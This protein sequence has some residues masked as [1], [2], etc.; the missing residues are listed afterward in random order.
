MMLEEVI[1][2]LLVWTLTALVGWAVGRI[3]STAKADKEEREALYAGVRALLRSELMRTHHQAI[4]DGFITTTDREVMQRTYDAYHTLHG[5]GVASVLYKEA[6]ELPTKEI[7][8]GD[9]A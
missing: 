9:K 7:Q 8:K 2:R 4:L 5:N 3:T 6:M 1:L